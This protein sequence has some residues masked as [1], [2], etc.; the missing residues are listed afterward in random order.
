MEGA[1]GQAHPRVARPTPGPRHQG[2]RTPG[3]PP[4][5]ALPPIYS[6]RW[7]KPKDPINFP[8]NILLAAIIIDTRSK[9]P[10]AL[11]APLPERGIPAG[12]LLHHHGRL[13][14]DV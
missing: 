2:V 11:P 14:S 12:G 7:E 5:A 6:P 3:P 1:T 9:D 13:W 4:D 10:G 8:R